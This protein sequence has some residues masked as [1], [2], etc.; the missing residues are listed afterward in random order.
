MTKSEAKAF[1]SLKDEEK[2][3]KSDFWRLNSNL[4]ETIQK[5]SKFLE[6]DLKISQSMAFEGLIEIIWKRMLH[7][8]QNLINKNKRIENKPSNSSKTPEVD[9]ENKPWKNKK[10]LFGDKFVLNFLI[11]GLGFESWSFST[12]CTQQCFQL[13]FEL[14]DDYRAENRLLGME[15]L[16]S[17]LNSIPQNLL[18]SQYGAL[19]LHN[20]YPSLNFREE[21]IVSYTLAII[22]KCVHLPTL[23]IKSTLSTTNDFESLQFQRI[24]NDDEWNEEQQ[25]INGDSGKSL[26]NSFSN[27]V[28]QLE[29]SLF[30]PK[31]KLQFLYCLYLRYFLNLVG[32][33]AL[34]E[35]SRVSSI[36]EETIKSNH[37]ETVCCSLDCLESILKQCWPRFVNSFRNQHQSKKMEGFFK[38][39][40]NLPTSFSESTISDANISQRQ[41][42][43]LKLKSANCLKIIELIKQQQK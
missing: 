32:F 39:I 37:F 23:N 41:N 36:L 14:I 7:Q 1:N 5:I 42:Q 10:E 43:I 22:V 21:L 29:R 34:L 11:L 31:K 28:Q 8:N 40:S 13:I 33:G 16:W 18:R 26:E 25:S 30:L 2:V 35:L 20:I 15:C 9:D 3:S 27:I 4:N 6:N 24:S 17:L 12:R 19:V 38:L